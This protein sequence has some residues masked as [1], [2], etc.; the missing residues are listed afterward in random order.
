MS[1]QV[2]IVLIVAAAIV[3]VLYLFRDRLKKF[4]IKGSQDN[5]EANLEAYKDTAQNEPGAAGQSYGVNISGNKQVG[6]DNKIKVAQSSVNVSDNTQMGQ[7]QEI[8]VD[9]NPSGESS[10]ALKPDV[11]KQ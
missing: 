3:I 6:K 2:L 10:P 11:P 5:L 4:T 8:R 1:D 7:G 9:A